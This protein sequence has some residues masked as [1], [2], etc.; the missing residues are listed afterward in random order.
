MLISNFKRQIQ[1][2]KIT[3]IR[4]HR[5][6]ESDAEIPGIDIHRLPF[7]EQFLELILF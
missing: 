2:P 1:F 3:Q 6:V 5:I 4:C 7:W